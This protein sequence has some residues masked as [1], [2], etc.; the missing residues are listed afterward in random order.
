MQAA[1][2]QSGLGVRDSTDLEG[3]KRCLR[4]AGV[5]MPSS[6][7][8]AGKSR[9]YARPSALPAQSGHDAS[10][11]I[12]SLRP[13]AT[14]RRPCPRRSAARNT[15]DV[16][17]PGGDWPFT[18]HTCR[19]PR[20]ASEATPEPRNWHDRVHWPVGAFDL[21]AVPCA[22]EP[23]PHAHLGRG[24]ERS[25]GVGTLNAI[26]PFARGSEWL[27]NPAFVVPEILLGHS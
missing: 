20:M 17:S 22:H 10:S 8:R 13:T 15:A 11:A 26:M 24:I 21:F 16:E 14:D 5:A 25:G 7:P 23:P 9:P 6:P 3:C 1:L 4:Q 27:Q 2:A 12:G 19:R 18:T